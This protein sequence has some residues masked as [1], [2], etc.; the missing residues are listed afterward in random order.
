VTD[1]RPVSQADL[2]TPEEFHAALLGLKPCTVFHGIGPEV[3]AQIREE[4]SQ[5]KAPARIAPIYEPSPELRAANAELQAWQDW[6]DEQVHEAMRRVGALEWT[7]PFR[8][9]DWRWLR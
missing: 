2:L 6:V 9:D 8:L 4:G 7:N 1:R 5:P 3:L